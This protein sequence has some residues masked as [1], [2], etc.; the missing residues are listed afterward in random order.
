LFAR[1]RKNGVTEDWLE[2]CL[3]EFDVKKILEQ[4]LVGKADRNK[5]RFRD[6]LKKTLYNFAIE[7]LRSKMSRPDA[8]TL[9]P[10]DLERAG[11]QS[12]GVLEADVAWARSIL[13][14]ALRRMKRECQAKSQRA[15]W[16][17]FKRRRLEPLLFGREC[18]S[19]EETASAVRQTL[20]EGITL[21]QVSARQKTG[22][23]KLCLH[24]WNV[25][26]EYCH[27]ADEIAAEEQSL[28]EIL[29]RSFR[30]ER[31]RSQG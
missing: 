5:G 20:G 4:N 26:S 22:E 18:E 8:V 10:E 16:L 11:F 15:I 28:F 27:D 25:L 12:E 31:V 23:R 1:L 21:D 9:E 6:L 13:G 17:I 19:L 29:T 14:Q 30:A 3:Q 24:R 7:R 2:E